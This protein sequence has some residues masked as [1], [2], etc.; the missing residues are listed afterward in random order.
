MLSSHVKRSP[1]LWLH[2]KS[3]LFHWCLYN[4]QNITCPLV[5]MNFIFE[6]STRYLS[7]ERSERVRYRFEHSEIKFL[8]MHPWASSI[9]YV[10][11]IPHSGGHSSTSFRCLFPDREKAL[12]T[13]SESYFKIIYQVNTKNI[14][15]VEEVW[16]YFSVYSLVFVSIEKIYQTFPFAI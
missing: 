7:G 2:N 8:S 10:L 11:V 12:E 1:S 16:L 15:R 3:R 14:A 5:D 6:C 13:R 4:N 9:L